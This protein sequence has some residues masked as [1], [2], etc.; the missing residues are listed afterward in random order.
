MLKSYNGFSGAQR[1]RG[2]RILKKA[3]EN[4]IIPAPSKCKCILCG[5]DK[6]IRHYHNED[7]SDE[8]VVSDA[9]V[10]CW[11]C[12]MMLHS[13]FRHPLSFGQYII[14]V[15]INKKQFPPVFRG[16]AWEELER[17]FID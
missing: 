1:E 17:H 15:T 8:N 14:D 10:L 5:Q 13:R 7:Y 12:H 4:G 9:K 6:G 16:N 11:R 2:A 3:I